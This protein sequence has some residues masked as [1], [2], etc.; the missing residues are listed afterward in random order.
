[1][2]EALHY[3]HSMGVIHRDLKPAN[4]FLHDSVRIG[5]FGLASGDSSVAGGSELQSLADGSSLTGGVGTSL[6]CAPE[7]L[8]AQTTTPTTADGVNSATTSGPQYD[9]RADMYSMGIV[10]FELSQPHFATGSERI[11]V[12]RALR[13]KGQFPSDYKGNEALREAILWLT[14]RD[15]LQRPTAE[16]VL[17]STLLPLPPI[18]LK[19]V[20]EA[21]RNDAEATTNLV[22]SL[23][24]DEFQSS[25]GHDT[26]TRHHHDGYDRD[27]LLSTIGMTKPHV[28]AT[29]D[30]LAL[31]K[32]KRKKREKEAAE[33]KE[34]E[35]NQ[36]HTNGGHAQ[37]HVPSFVVPVQVRE[38]VVEALTDIFRTRGA[39]QIAAPLL[40]LSQH[41]EDTTERSSQ[42]SHSH[43]HSHQFFDRN[44][45]LVN[46]Q[47]N[48]LSGW[49]NLIAQSGISCMRRYQVGTVFKADGNNF[50]QHPSQ[51]MEAVFDV[52]VPADVPSQ[53]A[54]AE[55][56]TLCVCLDILRQLRLESNVRVRISDAR[57]VRA[58]AEVCLWGVKLPPLQG[59]G[60]GQGGEAQTGRAAREACCAY[61]GATT[62]VDASS[63]AL[64]SA[65]STSSLPATV[66]TRLNIFRKATMTQLSGGD[67]AA[68]VGEIEREF[69]KSDAVLALQ[70]QLSGSRGLAGAGAGISGAGGVGAGSTS[71]IDAESRKGRTATTTA[72]TA[73]ATPSAVGVQ[74][75]VKLADALGAI[76][77]KTGQLQR[78]AA[79]NAVTAT[80]ATVAAVDKDK[81]GKS[82]SAAHMGTHTEAELAPEAFDRRD[83]RKF[84]AVLKSFDSAVS[85]TK[86]LLVAV[87]ETRKN[88]QSAD[89]NVLGR[90]QHKYEEEVSL[91]FDLVIAPDPAGLFDT[92]SLR[93]VCEVDL[94]RNRN[95]SIV[96]RKLLEGG[97]FDGLV[98]SFAAAA[99]DTHSSS[100][101]K[102]S[103]QQSRVA[104]IG[105][106][107]NVDFLASLMLDGRRLPRSILADVVVT[108][109]SAGAGAFGKHSSSSTAVTAGDEQQVNMVLSLLRGLSL[110]ATTIPHVLT[111]RQDQLSFRQML[112]ACAQFGV[113]TMVT[114]SA[115][116]AQHVNVYY[117]YRGS[118]AAAAA[119][120]TLQ[121]LPGYLKARRAALNAG[122]GDAA[123]N[124]ALVSSPAPGDRERKRRGSAAVE[125][126]SHGHGHAALYSP[127]P[128]A[129]AAAAG[130]PHQQQQRV[131]EV[132]LV[133]VSS[134]SGGS[135][136]SAKDKKGL[137]AKRLVM[138]QKLEPFLRTLFGSHYRLVPPQ[139]TTTG[140]NGGG[141]SGGGGFSS[142]SGNSSSSGSGSA[143][144]PTIIVSDAKQAT[145]R[146]LISHVDEVCKL[147]VRTGEAVRK[148]SMDHLSLPSWAESDRRHVKMVTSEIRRLVGTINS[149]GS[150]GSGGSSS[151][152]AVLLYSAAD[153]R[154]DMLHLPDV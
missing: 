76:G 87:Q 5:D 91:R 125:G 25:S 12:I 105:L 148:L 3:F 59:Q 20:T 97:R 27:L 30:A 147:G 126:Q 118:D 73:T 100:K 8:S 96:T 114:V 106:R 139:H 145:L 72:A 39:A 120:L 56:D 85:R 28:T 149:G 16:D 78:A 13:E 1:M 35:Q 65:A 80:Q 69:F 10:L 63:D 141:G 64:N 57:I 131:V 43:S 92:D 115:Q 46:L 38:L 49:A 26:R 55:H 110:R 48:L 70:R 116:D 50:D 117:P 53:V 54:E 98:A 33:A 31:S 152:Q 102:D 17:N 81:K 67:P 112:E 143:G 101:D 140:S 107:T 121:E 90:D 40:H 142:G 89:A 86:Q 133:N 45:R 51:K 111:G 68:A 23:F 24:S 77:K 129:P 37:S 4:I 6:Y 103:K 136:A 99:A 62:S 127:G 2:L 137:A 153:D 95:R 94:P 123:G 83:L 14:R 124:L 7:V 36:Q 79:A 9:V 19:E 32:G 41:Q 18:D 93:F 151:A 21:L 150:S 66:L 22:R 138:Q 104:C 88:L 108:S 146:L 61:L 52:T 130:Q 44:G 11:H 134:S 84:R 144:G 154:L 42:P 15:P 135:S 113:S 74:G 60:Q 29:A 122:K 119:L 71:F 132:S 109:H 82:P 75:Q 34:A 58:I 128:A 47:T